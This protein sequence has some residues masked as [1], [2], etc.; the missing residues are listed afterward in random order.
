MIEG[1]GNAPV[2]YWN[3]GGVPTGTLTLKLVEVRNEGLEVRDSIWKATRSLIYIEVGE[4]KD[5]VMAHMCPGGYEI[6][7]SITVG[8]IFV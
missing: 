2:E 8:E 5:V 6:V 7:G 3:G 4:C 1:G